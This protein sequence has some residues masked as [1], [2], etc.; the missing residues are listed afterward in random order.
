LLFSHISTEDCVQGKKLPLLETVQSLML[1]DLATIGAGRCFVFALIHFSQ[2]WKRI[3]R[4]CWMSSGLPRLEHCVY[5]ILTMTGTAAK[6][7]EPNWKS[8]LRRRRR[9]EQVCCR[10]HSQLTLRG[11]QIWS[12]AWCVLRKTLKYFSKRGR[13]LTEGVFAT[14]KAIDESDVLLQCKAIGLEEPV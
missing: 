7:S 5:C 6:M 12:C 3:I 1:A 2:M 10:F 13:I 14:T 9:R 11:Y 8:S 4:N